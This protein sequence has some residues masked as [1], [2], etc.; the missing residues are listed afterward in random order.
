MK[1]IIV[2][3]VMMLTGIAL[4]EAQVVKSIALKPGIVWANQK[5]EW[6]NIQDI[7]EYKYKT[8]LHM[9]VNLEFL[10]HKFLSIIAEGGYIEKGM[11]QEIELT[12]PE[13]PEG[14]GEIK[15]FKTSFRYA[16]LSPMLK[17]RIE[18]RNF[19][20]Y[21][22]V[23]PRVDFYLSYK[24]DLNFDELEEEMNKTIFGMI[25][26]LGL[27]YMLGPVGI[28]LIYSQQLDFMP[29][30]ENEPPHGFGLEKITNNAFILDLGVKYYFG[31]IQ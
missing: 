1:K 21:V 3:F 11:V 22:F 2:V 16:Y 8:G 19:V 26:G 29:A 15:T 24:S 18:F 28:A 23:G 9:G 31:K 30:M 6:I 14:S 17:A 27:E 10:Q 4:L 25:Y 13:M 20:P 5:W 7:A 12:T